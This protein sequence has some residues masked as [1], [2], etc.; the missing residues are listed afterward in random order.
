MPN[1]AAAHPSRSSVSLSIVVPCYR[2]G[3]WLA[4]LVERIEKST[5]AHAGRRELILVDDASPDAE[6]WPAIQ[7]AAERY[8]WVRGIS[9]AFN[10]GQYCALLAG[11][12]RAQGDWVVTLDDDLQTPPEEV[13]VL[14]RA[15]LERP[16][17]DAVIG[18]YE[19]KRHS[20][21]RNLGTWTL[22]R[23]YT[24][25]SG[26]PEDVQS[27]SFRALSRELVQTLCAHQT[28]H[29]MLGAM[30][31]ESTRRVVNVSVAHQ[32]RERGTSGYTLSKLGRLLLGYVVSR[33][34]APLHAILLLGLATLVACAGLFAAGLVRSLV[35]GAPFSD[36]GGPT[37]ALGVVGGAVLVALG[38]VGEYVHVL[39]RE[40]IGRPRTVVR[41][42]CGAARGRGAAQ[43]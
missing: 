19:V 41:E 6:T 30:I 36:T 23:A 8:D 9:L 27:T 33:S 12:E 25:L 26:K 29:P 5:L 42:E 40:L 18:C 3:A 14:L 35:S 1:S 17:L 11:L 4:E 32:P 13:P 10:A 43:R 20:R 37:L 38:I 21:I 2:S 24:L 31:F 39:Q 22:D 16:D 15:A 34:A 7:R 28:R